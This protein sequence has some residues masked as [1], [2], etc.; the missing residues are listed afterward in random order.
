[1]KLLLVLFSLTALATP[2]PTPSLAPSPVPEPEGKGLGSQLEN[3]VKKAGPRLKS[4]A[5][6]AGG[7]LDTTGKKIRRLFH[8]KPADEK[9]TSKPE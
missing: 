6:D 4:A 5:D 9:T 7:V 8:G 3:R 2:L 1:M